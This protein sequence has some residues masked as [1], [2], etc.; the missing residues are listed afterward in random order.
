MLDTPNV[1]PDLSGSGV[2]R[3]MIDAALA[4]L[5]A[6]RLLWACD[7]TM[8][9]GLAKLRAL[10][11]IGLSPDELRRRALAQRGAALSRRHLPALRELLA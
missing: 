4:A 6:R 9:T 7:L 5:G 2:D 10:E 3:G 11:V 8:E 1:H